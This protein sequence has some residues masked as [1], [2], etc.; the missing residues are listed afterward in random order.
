[1]ASGNTVN[2][3]RIAVLEIKI[4]HKGKGTKEGQIAFLPDNDCIANDDDKIWKVRDY[5]AE[6]EEIKPVAPF[7]FTGDGFHVIDKIGLN[8]PVLNKEKMN[9]DVRYGKG[10]IKATGTDCKKNGKMRIQNAIFLKNG[11]F[12]KYK[13]FGPWSSACYQSNNRAF[14]FY[15]KNDNISVA[16]SHNKGYAWFEF[17]NIIRLK[18]NERASRP[19]VVEDLE[20][21]DAYLFFILNDNFL[22][23]KQIPLAYFHNQDSY[24]ISSALGVWDK[25]TDDDTGLHLLEKG[26]MAI[27]KTP[28]IIIAGDINSGFDIQKEIKISEERAKEGK[29]YR[30]V[31]GVDVSELQEN[32][33]HALFCAYRDNKGHIKLWYVVDGRRTPRTGKW[34]I[35]DSSNIYNWSV[36]QK[37]F[38]FAFPEIKKYKK[39]M[40]EMNASLFIECNDIKN[41]SGKKAK[42]L[43]EDS[44]Y[45]YGFKKNKDYS[46]C[47]SGSGGYSG[48]NNYDDSYKNYEKKKKKKCG[49]QGIQQIQAV[50]DGEKDFVRIIF[51]YEDGI[52]V[53]EMD[54]ALLY[55][56]AGVERKKGFKDFK[57]DVF[58]KSSNAQWIIYHYLDLHPKD[59]SPNKPIFLAGKKTKHDGKLYLDPH[60]KFNNCEDTS[61]VA[62]GIQPSGIITDKGFMKVYYMDEKGSLWNLCIFPKI[63]SAIQTQN[64]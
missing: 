20:N 23:V 37:D 33:Q 32:L 14:V 39:E 17:N 18:G 22:C 50:Y 30:F 8:N 31:L 60:Y 38:W 24:I 43:D 5:F 47:D 35:L 13:T 21:N 48:N 7:T 25:N 1:M 3:D 19:Y 61:T 9:L 57:P 29:S 4:N 59:K 16:M 62:T 53:R 36:V 44:S 64:V 10:R 11:Y 6:G 12:N 34:K 46:G 54:N 41:P 28:S 56:V 51:I 40:V 52:Y 63:S 2:V 49:K 26:G 27:R 45:D 58:K 15:E 55:I 42:P